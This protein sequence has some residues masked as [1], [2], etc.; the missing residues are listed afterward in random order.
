[1][2]WLVTIRPSAETKLPEPPLLKRT[3]AC[4]ARSSQASVRSKS[5]LS[6]SSLRGGSL[7]S[8]MPSSAFTVFTR[9]KASHTRRAA[10]AAGTRISRLTVGPAF[11]PGDTVGG[12]VAVRRAPQ[13]DRS[14]PCVSLAGL[15][16]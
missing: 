1:M 15:L 10:T 5:Y 11:R 13:E 16:E 9:E 14:A 12:I 3:D 4:W 8:H 2:W 7:S 6:L